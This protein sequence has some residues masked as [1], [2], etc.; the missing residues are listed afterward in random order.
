MKRK[1]ILP[2]LFTNLYSSA[3]NATVILM[4]LH[5][6]NK[7]IN[8]LVEDVK[9]S[10]MFHL[11]KEIGSVINLIIIF[12]LFS[13]THFVRQVSGNARVELLYINERKKIRTLI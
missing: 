4:C 12:L 7:E 5:H 8:A 3:V 10:G 13:F 11:E 1:L 6:C 9:C 2:I